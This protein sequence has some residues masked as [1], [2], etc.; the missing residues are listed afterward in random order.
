MIAKT[1]IQ[2]LLAKK[3]D[4]KGHWYLVELIVSP[5]NQIKVVL[6]SN[7]GFTIDDC[8]EVTRYIE[9]NIDREVEDFELEVSSA[10]L[11]EPFKVEQQYLK[12]LGK[13][14]EV[15]TKTGQKLKGFLKSYERNKIVIEAESMVKLEGSKRKQKVV[16]EHL[17]NIDDLKS[18]KLVIEFK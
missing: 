7:T 5:S 13:A 3:I 2:E 15:L 10:G 9:K 16:K 6:D 12:N 1:F 8:V 11:S 4:E 17:F 14:V 18:V